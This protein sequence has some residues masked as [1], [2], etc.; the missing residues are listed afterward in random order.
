MTE[1]MHPTRWQRNLRLVWPIRPDFG[2][3]WLDPLES[4]EH[5]T[6]TVKSKAATPR[7]N[8]RPQRRVYPRLPRRMYNATAMM[9]KITRIVINM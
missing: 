1:F 9:A 7:N 8:S 4:A 6:P 5:G 3:G 2:S